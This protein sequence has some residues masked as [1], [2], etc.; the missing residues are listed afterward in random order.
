[1]EGGGP[2]WPPP[3][4]LHTL[5]ILLS[6]LLRG[7]SQA[8]GRRFGHASIP[9]PTTAPKL[10]PPPAPLGPLVLGQSSCSGLSGGSDDVSSDAAFDSAVANRF[11]SA[12]GKGSIRFVAAGAYSLPFTVRVTDVVCLEVGALY[13]P[14]VM[15]PRG[16]SKATVA[17][18]APPGG[19]QHKG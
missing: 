2:A 12:G 1:M 18:S 9:P 4:K 14:G 6:L 19:S 16:R 5:I 7:E 11:A 10:G 8:P 3:L 13:T 17:W 15:C